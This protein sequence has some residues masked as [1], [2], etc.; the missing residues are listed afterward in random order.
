MKQRK[1]HR[2][3]LWKSLKG[4]KCMC[5]WSVGRITGHNSCLKKYQGTLLRMDLSLVGQSCEV[6][7]QEAIAIVQTRDD[8]R[9]KLYVGL[10]I[11]R[12]YFGVKVDI[13]C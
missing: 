3:R 6:Y 2:R 12:R 11:L 4:F 7:S 1:R 5:V 13:S 8:G 9:L 10:E